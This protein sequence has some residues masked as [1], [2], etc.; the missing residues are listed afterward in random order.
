M[1]ADVE[2]PMYATASQEVR[3]ADAA[4]S[5]E[6]VAGSEAV[7]GGTASGV[8][9]VEMLISSLGTSSEGCATSL[10]SAPMLITPARPATSSARTLSV[11]I[12]ATPAANRC[13]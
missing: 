5:D 12:E 1:P 3:V 13:S 9:S 8:Y 7:V 11:A 10:S 6:E 2:S 4:L